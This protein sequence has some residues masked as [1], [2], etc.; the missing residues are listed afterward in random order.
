MDESWRD[1]IVGEVELLECAGEIF[2]GGNKH[3]GCIRWRWRNVDFGKP[4]NGVSDAWRGR[5]GDNDVVR[6]IMGKCW[7]VACN[8]MRCPCTPFLRCLV[9]EYCRTGR[10]NRV[11]AKVERSTS[12]AVEKR[13]GG[14]WLPR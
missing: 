12:E 11:R 3:F 7:T 4:C 10:G 8:T 6:P 5:S 1:K 13:N 14:I 2:D 9:N